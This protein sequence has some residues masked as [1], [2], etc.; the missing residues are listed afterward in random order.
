MRK[1]EFDLVM[2][3]SQLPYAA[4]LLYMYLRHHM[5]Y[6]SSV[7]GG[8]KRRISYIGIREHLEYLP[9]PCS[10]DKP[11]KVSKP[12][13]RGLVARLEA[14]GAIVAMH[15]KSVRGCMVFFLPFSNPE[16]VCPTDEEHMTSTGQAPIAEGFVD[17]S[18]GDE[19]HTS[20]DLNLTTLELSNI[21]GRESIN[22]HDGRIYSG[23]VPSSEMVDQL[24]G[25]FGFSK[26]FIED[27]SFRFRIYWKD[28]GGSADSWNLKFYN[29][30]R[31]RVSDRASEFMQAMSQNNLRH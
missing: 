28:R 17:N 12:Q 30:V 16:L 24:V 23:W 15:D 27:I 26:G 14:L 25:E 29:H 8:S 10:K 7:V 3:D 18:R 20:I 22:N 9:L 6:A 4:K 13:A 31:G 19:A 5:D 1:K 2:M 21:S 11:I